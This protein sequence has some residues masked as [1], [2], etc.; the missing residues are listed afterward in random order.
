MRSNF[1]NVIPGQRNCGRNKFVALT[2]D[3]QT[4]LFDLFLT[5]LRVDHAGFCRVSSAATCGTVL[6]APYT[7]CM[8][9]RHGCNCSS[10]TA[11]TAKSRASVK[12]PDI[13]GIL[14]FPR[15]RPSPQS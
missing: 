10:P 4:N 14:A 12:D 2:M 1:V 3:F 6:T 8:R 7:R 11:A 9:S 5:D 15:G 13:A